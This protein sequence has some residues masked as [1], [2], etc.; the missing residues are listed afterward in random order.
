MTAPDNSPSPLLTPT[1]APS[2]A[3]VGAQ[4]PLAELQDIHTPPD[5]GIWP[6]AWGW[7]LVALLAISAVL[8]IIFFARRHRQRNHYRQ[9][10]LVE[11][12]QLSRIDP[13]QNGEWLQALSIL[14]RRTAIAGCGPQFDTGLKG[15]A[16]LVWLDER[17]PDCDMQFS[18]GAGTAL[19]AGPYQKNPECDR[20]ALQQLAQTWIRAHRNRWQKMSKKDKNNGGQDV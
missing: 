18:Q 1:P 4:D 13:E 2:P 7:W 9:E 6:P 8:A 3:Q 17:C 10:A 12:Q 11:L 5:I 19:L 15:N 16:W 14:L 20:V